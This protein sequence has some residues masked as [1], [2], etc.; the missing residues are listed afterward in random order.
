MERLQMLYDEV[1]TEK[2]DRDDE[3]VAFEKRMEKVI[4]ELQKMKVMTDDLSSERNE[5]VD[6]LQQNERLLRNKQQEIIILTAKLETLENREEERQEIRIKNSELSRQVQMLTKKI[7]DKERY[8][9][10]K[11][12]RLTAEKQSL[13]TELI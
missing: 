4:K 11:M 2:Q 10:D 9:K 8:M 7:D 12:D 5:A 13:E 6:Q 1:L 3:V